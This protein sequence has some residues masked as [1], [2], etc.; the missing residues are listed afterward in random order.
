MV[1]VNK[2]VTKTRERCHLQK[3]EKVSRSLNDHGKWKT[4]CVKII[5]R[6]KRSPLFLL[7]VHRVS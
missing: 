6:C 5:W 3:V 4:R 1:Y 7:T 2:T